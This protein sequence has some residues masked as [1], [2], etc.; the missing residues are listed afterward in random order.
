MPHVVL[1][2]YRDT[3]CILPNYFK[4]A[5]PGLARHHLYT[6][7]LRLFWIPPRG[8][9]IIR[10]AAHMHT[11]HAK[12]ES[13]KHRLRLRIEQQ[14]LRQG[15]DHVDSIKPLRTE[16]AQTVGPTPAHLTFD[17]TDL[18]IQA[19]GLYMSALGFHYM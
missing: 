3:L 12:S 4:T 17:L 15:T 5:D 2:I 9:V 18:C 16:H 7:T 19:P 13:S 14:L 11:F 8:R 1:S 6:H 10:Q